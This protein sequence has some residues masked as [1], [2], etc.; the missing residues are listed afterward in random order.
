MHDQQFLLRPVQL[1]PGEDVDALAALV[2][3][4]VYE[5]LPLD[6]GHV[7]HIQLRDDG[8][9]AGDLGEPHA[10][11]PHKGP[12]VLGH[13]QLTGGDEEKLDALKLGQGL[14]EGVNR[15]AVLQIAAQ[16]HGQPV[17]LA[18]QAGDGGEI[19]SGLGGVHVAA[20]AGVDHRH[21]GVQG[22]RLGRALL[23]VAH[24]HH[25]GIAR[26]HL[27]GVLQGL[28]LGGGGGLGVGE[29]EHRAPHPQH[30]GLKGKV[31]AGGRLI[32]QAGHHPPT[33][34][35]HKIGGVV[36]NITAPLVQGLPLRPR[37]VS[38][39]DQMP[40]DASFPL[41]NFFYRIIFP[42]ARARAE[43]TNFYTFFSSALSVPP[44]C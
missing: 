15:A 27:D 31:G 3:Q 44:P 2:L 17:H 42:P 41:L 4:G 22:G 18:P 20:V 26:H 11:L 28:A 38:K 13:R 39:V 14:D 7:E 1:P 12:H 34:G 24:H 10:M 35:V 25:V 33:A 5:A 21:V 6:A 30:G 32:E 16:A 19:R 43:R 9:Q 8:L 36:H 29:A 37:Q 40:H 23:G